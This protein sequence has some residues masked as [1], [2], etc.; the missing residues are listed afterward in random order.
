MVASRLLALAAATGAVPA[1]AACDRSGSGIELRHVAFADADFGAARLGGREQGLRLR[2]RAFEFARGRLDFGA[3]YDYTHYRYTGL[4]TRD[5]DLHRLLLPLNWTGGTT[6]VT[7]LNLTP[8]VA[9]SSNV[10]KDLFGRG[11]GDD[12]ALYGRGVVERAPAQG[13][14]WRL[15]AVYDDAFG[16]PRVYPTLALLRHGERIAVE[17]GWPTSRVDWRAGESLCLGFAVA[18]A[19]RRWHVV[20]DE[21]D[22]A[23]FFYTTEAWRGA[24]GAEW[25][26]ARH[27]LLSA[28]LGYEFD[29][30]HD[31]E[32][33][34]G[35]RIERTAD[36]AGYFA[37]ALHYGLDAR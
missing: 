9:A 30:R 13:W 34:T 4:S 24:L 2:S 22:G 5:R 6:Y 25:A 26:F 35:A 3:D 10:F 14:G 21:R 16:D 15:G 23:E 8:T 32:D 17:L 29:R 19:G 1:D 11:D 28:E 36:S 31:F 37:L 27:W 20:S 33:D 18:P 12:F 7:R